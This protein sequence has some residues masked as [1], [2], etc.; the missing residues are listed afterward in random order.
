MEFI[1]ERYV[2][3]SVLLDA[4]VFVVHRARELRNNYYFPRGRQLLEREFDT[5]DTMSEKKVPRRWQRA[6]CPHCED[7]VSKSTYYRHREKYYDVR[8]GE[9]AKCEYDTTR[10]C[11]S[12]GPTAVADLGA[13]DSESTD[14]EV[15]FIGQAG[16][17]VIHT[18][19]VAICTR[20]YERGPQLHIFQMNLQILQAVMK[21]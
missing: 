3:V 21:T 9:W 11:S 15:D 12:A 6:F 2:P 16:Q 20:Q 18:S 5:W 7:T 10:G 13:S 1:G 8:S 14:E 19:P 17:C 4:A